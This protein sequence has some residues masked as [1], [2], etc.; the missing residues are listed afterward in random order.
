M[1]IP[2]H[3]AASLL[4]R[5]LFYVR[6]PGAFSWLTGAFVTN[7]RSSGAAGEKQAQGH[8]ARQPRHTNVSVKGGR[9]LLPCVGE[10]MC[11]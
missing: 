6:E 9:P 1:L 4:K 3:L 2:A 5:Q 8:I 11:F 7:L 10:K